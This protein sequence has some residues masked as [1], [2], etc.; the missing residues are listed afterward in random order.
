MKKFLSI[1]VVCTV[2][3]S[4]VNANEIDKPK[5]AAG[6]AVVKSESGFKL[7]YKGE[8]RGDIKVTIYDANGEAVY[9]ETVRRIESF[10][11]PYNL[12]SLK[13]GDYTVEI[14]DENGVQLK[15]VNYSVKKDEGVLAKLTPIAGE[16]HKYVLTVPNKSGNESFSIKIY[17][18]SRELVYEATENV[19]GDFAK[20]Y[21]LEKVGGS[22]SFEISDS[23]G[24]TQLLGR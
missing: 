15:K 22:F 4:A 2:I 17:N 14:R 16:A 3:A 19:T 23:K 6:V 9:K 24:N 7:F 1:L 11:R 10:I 18:A 8:K 13:E 21:T 20:M 12:G 5:A